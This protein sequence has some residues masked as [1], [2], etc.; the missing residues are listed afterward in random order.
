[1]VSA[2]KKNATGLVLSGNKNCWEY[3]K[4]EN[5]NPLNKKQMIKVKTE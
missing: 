4:N 5:G 2:Q 3:W 1:M